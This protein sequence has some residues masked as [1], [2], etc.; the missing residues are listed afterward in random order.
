MSHAGAVGTF[1]AV[2][3]IL[4][5]IGLEAVLS[6]TL[7]AQTIAEAY[8]SKASALNEK[9]IWEAYQLANSI[10]QPTGGLFALVVG[11]IFL[12]MAAYNLTKSYERKE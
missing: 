1:G 2:G 3:T 10:T 6:S 4:T 11:S 7:N 8:L 5:G 9:T 12:G